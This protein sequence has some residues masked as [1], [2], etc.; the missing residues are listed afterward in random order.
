MSVVINILLFILI[1][2]FIIFIHEF[3]HFTW[4]KLRGVYVYE[5]SMGMGPLI[6][7][8]KIGETEYSLRAIP[9]GGY[10]ALAGEDV[11]YDNNK[12]IP[13]NRRLQNKKPWERFL[14]MF[15]GAGNNFLSAFVI[16]FLIGIIWGGT[17]LDPMITEVTPG[18][19]ADKA[20][21]VEN[22][23]VLEINGNKIK[24]SDDISLFLAV[25]DP[26]EGSTFKIL[27]N[28]GIVEIIR[29][30]PE[31]TKIDGK[32][33][34]I[35]GIGMQQEKTHGF[36]NAVKYMFGKSAALFRQMWVTVKYLFTGHVSLNQ[37]SGP[38]GIYSIVGAQREAGIV[39]ILYLLAFLSINV[40]FLNLLPLPAFDG[41]HILFILI[42]LLRGKPVDPK[43]ENIIHNVGMALLMLLMLIVTVNDIIKLF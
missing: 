7:S 28:D 36:V 6:F 2:G 10:C 3:G 25:A 19:A 23:K 8:K 43:I 15:F 1:L 39:S 11:E 21:I 5:F 35:Y 12:K 4:A 42:E 9:V 38:V 31:K 27:G 26:K 40:G 30:V 17:T 29:V 32:S 41:G 16:L 18:S 24:S 14:I 22:T 13:K 34:Y 33:S 20:G 37:M